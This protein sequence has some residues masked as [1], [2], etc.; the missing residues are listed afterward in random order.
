MIKL[1]VE[2][3]KVSK[4]ISQLKL[5]CGQCRYKKI[6]KTGSY[7]VCP[8]LFLGYLMWVLGVRKKQFGV[9]DNNEINKQSPP[10]AWALERLTASSADNMIMRIY[11]EQEVK[12]GERPPASQVSGAPVSLY[13]QCTSA[14]VKVTFQVVMTAELGYIVTASLCTPKIYR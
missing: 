13:T 3:L 5:W 7:G 10:D 11:G 14:G 6:K 4:L 12:V 2:K 9:S 1:G 8:V